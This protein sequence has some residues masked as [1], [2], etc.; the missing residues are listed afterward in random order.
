[1]VRVAF[2]LLSN[3]LAAAALTLEEAVNLSLTRNERA[4]SADEVTRAAEARVGQA[5][6]FLLPDLTLLGDYTRRSHETTR[7]VD[8]VTSTLQSRDGREARLNLEQTLFDAQAWPL[9]QSARRARTA[10]RYDARDTKRLLAF[11]TADT[12]L[13]VLAADRVARA[14]GERLE[15]AERNLEEVRVRFDAQLVSS[16]DVTLAELEA[17]SAERELVRVRGLARTARLNLGQLLAVDIAESDSLIIPNMLLVDAARPVD[18]FP[19]PKSQAV[20][21]RPDVQAER[22]RAAAAHSIAR[23]PLMRYLPD[24]DF[25]GTAWSTNEAGF[26]GDDTDWTVGLGLTWEL[27]DGGAREAERSER[28]ALARAAEF[29]LAHLERRVAVDVEAAQVAVESQQAS[30]ARA[31][32]AVNAARRNATETTE[33][34]RRGLLRAFEVVDANVQ[35]FEAEV[36][37]TSAQY[38]LALAYLDL[39]AAVGLDPLDTMAVEEVEP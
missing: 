27:F 24:L 34:Y 37:R 5:R 16:N 19:V 28:A 30:L 35:L 18:E 22:A 12:Y 20:E 1:M 4:A 38:E 31:E 7:T 3:P 39:R 21:R 13:T 6:S 32:V 14:A 25:L 36:E 11:E 29:D 33:L 2:L 17:A 8:G 23:E 10:A 26:T 15:L 9:L